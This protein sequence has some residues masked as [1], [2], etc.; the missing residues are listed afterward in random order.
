MRTS[1][2][3]E[4]SIQSLFE[5]YFIQFAMITSKRTNQYD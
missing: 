2:K 3:K 4:N 5:N 1:V